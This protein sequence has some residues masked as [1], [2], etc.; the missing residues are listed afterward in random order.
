M[1]DVVVEGRES[2]IVAVAPKIQLC[3]FIEFEFSRWHSLRVS[4]VGGIIV[5][6]G[7][8]M[9]RKIQE[10]FVDKIDILKDTDA[11]CYRKWLPLSNGC[12]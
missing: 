10:R 7:K 4:S 1:K 11:K 6:A 8:D 2:R 3:F 12:G 9:A 5:A